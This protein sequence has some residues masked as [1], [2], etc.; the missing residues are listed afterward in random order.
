MARRHSRFIRPQ[1]RT[2]MW[3]GNGVGEENIAG[4]TKVL[5]ST[6]SAGALLLRPFTI[7]RTHLLIQARSDQSTA[8]ESV[9]AAYGEMVVTDTAAAIGATAVPNPSGI[10]GDPE[11]DWFLWQAIAFQFFID[12]NGTDGIGLD[13]SN[14]VS[15]A[16][17]SKAMRKVGPD[18]NVVA[19]TVSELA[20]GF[21]LVT[22]GRMLIQLH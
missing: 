5:S 8:V 14:G 18:D 4:S 13:G 7:L 20:T 3:I 2:K 19:V 10:S 17:D 15:Y 6:L 16:V 21:V 11:A 1:P 12:I 22:Q 9:V